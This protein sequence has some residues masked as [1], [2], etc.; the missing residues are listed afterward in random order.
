MGTVPGTAPRAGHHAAPSHL[1][2]GITAHAIM[3]C[4]IH[5]IFRGSM[6][7]DNMASSEKKT[8]I[9]STSDLTLEMKQHT[10]ERQQNGKTER[11]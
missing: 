10:S 9:S 6:L 1:V 7:K 11:E 2:I 5:P 3:T 8:T 4:C